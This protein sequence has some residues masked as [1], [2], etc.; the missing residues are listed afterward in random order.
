M[1]VSTTWHEGYQEWLTETQSLQNAQLVANHFKGSDWSKESIS[2]LVGNMRHESSV[3][4]NMSEYG[5]DFSADRGFGLVQWTPR[6]KYWDWATARNLPQRSG[7]SQLDRIDYEVENNIQWIKVSKAYN[8]TFAQFRANT[9]GLNV[10]QLT[11]AFTWGYERPLASAGESSMPDRQA[12][13]NKAL[14]ELDWTG[15]GTG[16]GGGTDPTTPS[17]TGT[18]RPILDNTKTPQ[19]KYETEGTLNGMAYYKVKNGDTLSKIAKN[20][21][22]K[23]NEILKVKYSLVLNQNELKVGEVLLLPSSVKSTPTVA[24]TNKTYTVKSG[25]YLGKIASNLKVTEKHLISKNKLKN[26]DKILVGQKLVY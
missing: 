22:V 5:Y 15:T 19:Y 9:E 11:E 16:G 26:P 10:N 13:A 6:S 20:N 12:F 1:V 18:T 8:L 2:A 23:M 24:S 21:N 7:D 4:P 17:G 3:N 25:D 14:N